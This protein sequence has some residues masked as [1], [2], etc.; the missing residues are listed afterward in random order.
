VLLLFL[1]LLLLLLIYVLVVSLFFVLRVCVC[2]CFVCFFLA[3][4][5]HDGDEPEYITLHHIMMPYIVILRKRG[6]KSNG[7]IVGARCT[8]TIASSSSSFSGGRS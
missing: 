6:L 3:A 8:C 2:V 7:S 4:L 5:D 1:L